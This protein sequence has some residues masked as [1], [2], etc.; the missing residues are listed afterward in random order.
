[1]AQTS[2]PFENLDT[3]ETQFSQWAKNINEGVKQGNG[4][5]LVVTAD[6]TGMTVSVGSGQSMIR[7][8]YYSS[9][10]SESLAITAS[11]PTNPRIDAV[12]LELDPT[13]NTVLL[14]VLA[15]T[16]AGSP[17]APTLTQTEAGVYQLPLAYIAVAATVLAIELVDVTD[18]RGFMFSGIGKWTTANRPT[19]PV[20][21]QTTGYNTTINAHEFWNGT[22]W[23]GFADPITTEG[24]LIVG[25]ASGVPERLPVGVDDQV[26]TVVAGEPT[27]ADAASGGGGSVTGS[28]PGQAVYATGTTKDTYNFLAVGNGQ[29]IGFY[30]ANAFVKH[31]TLKQYYAPVYAINGYSSQYADRYTAS[32]GFTDGATYPMTGARIPTNYSNPYGA[33]ANVTTTSAPDGGTIGDMINYDPG[34][35]RFWAY[36]Y[37]P[38]GLYL[39]YSDDNGV[40]WTQ[41]IPAVGASTN[42][43]VVGDSSISN[44]VAYE[45]GNGQTTYYTSSNGGT[46]WTQ[47]TFPSGD[48]LNKIIWDGTKFVGTSYT[49]SGRTRY[50][51]TSTDGISWTTRFSFTDGNSNLTSQNLVWNG[52]T[53]ANSKFVLMGE[54]AYTNNYTGQQNWS[55][56]GGITWT[57]SSRITAYINNVAGGNGY[58]VASYGAGTGS[59]TTVYYTQDPS[60]GWTQVDITEGNSITQIRFGKNGA[61]PNYQNDY[62][63]M[64]ITPFGNGFVIKQ[65]GKAFISGGDVSVYAYY[66]TEDFVTF[67]VIDMGGNNENLWN[68]NGKKEAFVDNNGFFYNRSSA[69]INGQFVNPYTSWV[70]FTNV[71]NFDTLN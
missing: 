65:Y 20:Q 46:S 39:T 21:Y 19:N 49:Y 24:D 30:G 50:I 5:E 67:N 10:A 52:L 54:Y 66:Y 25:G 2:W 51:L 44:M 12:V 1:M 58:F 4:D 28:S 69:T 64:D 40:S 59:S 37:D 62:Y 63:T 22:S 47:R 23:V 29:E 17:V 6:G 36:Y 33:W 60:A 13:A 45:S 31:P 26:L 56:D 15:G 27:W 48:S 11:D 53:G 34:A 61:A 3:T 35:N 14:K 16:P 68:Q 8:H 7:G 41:S 55:L 42:V 57:R 18:K 71:P 70:I 43:D 9:T 32:P 38:L